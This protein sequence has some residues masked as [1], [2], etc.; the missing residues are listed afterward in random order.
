MSIK[1][2]AHILHCHSHSSDGQY[3]ASRLSKSI[4]QE[5]AKLKKLLKE[6]NALTVS[7]DRVLTWAE[8]T[9]LSTRTLSDHFSTSNIPRKICLSAIKHYHLTLRADEE[10]RLI[11]CEM[12]SCI[13]FFLND[14]KCLVSTA[15][16]LKSKPNSKFHNG[17]LH[18][19]QQTRM[20]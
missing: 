17:A 9:D 19:V 13:S 18:Q 4:N 15:L 11:K 12:K 16:E 2:D 1:I 7:G 3:M 10:I 8:A 5:S 6:Y 20:R 14:W